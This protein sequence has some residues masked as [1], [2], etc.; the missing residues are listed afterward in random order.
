[1]LL[2]AGLGVFYRIPTVIDKIKTIDQFTGGGIYF[3]YFCFYFIGVILTGGG[4]KKI[5]YNI[6]YINRNKNDRTN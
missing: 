1:M 6:K 2:F 3:A 4:I 5:L